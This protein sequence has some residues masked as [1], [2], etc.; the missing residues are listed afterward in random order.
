MISSNSFPYRSSISP[1]HKNDKSQTIDEHKLKKNKQR[2]SLQIITS[3]EQQ[4]Y[5]VKSSS[6]KARQRLSSLIFG[7]SSPVVMTLKDAFS[8]KRA[9][10]STA[11]FTTTPT[12]ASSE[13]IEE[14]EEDAQ[15]TT[16]TLS[17]NSSDHMPASPA[18][19]RIIFDKEQQLQTTIWQPSVTILSYPEEE[20]VQQ[21]EQITTKPQPQ[22]TTSLAYQVQQILGSAL[23]EVDEEI[24]QDWEKSRN[25]LRQS[26]VLPSNNRNQQFWFLES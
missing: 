19:A 8:N 2:Q 22:R 14:E 21:E 11:S 3:P 26:L 4:E 1:F 5:V 6:K 16:T 20:Q 23:D 18:D 24:D 13:E 25:V 17:S 7:T 12:T 15:S 10:M 9:S